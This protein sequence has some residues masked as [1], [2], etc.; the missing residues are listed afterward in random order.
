MATPPVFYP[1]G[2]IIM[3]SR[4]TSERRA[5]LKPTNDVIQAYSY[6]LG[7]LV[8]K[9]G[10][11]L[12][13]ANLVMTHD[14]KLVTDPHGDR[15]P[16]FN[17]DFNSLVARCL[18]C[19]YG[20]WE[21]F[22]AP[23]GPGDLEVAPFPEDV[24]DKLAYVLTNPV[25]DGLIERTT[26]WPALIG[27]PAFLGRQEIRVRRP[28]WFFSPDG[29]MPDWVTLRPVLPR[30]RGLNEEEVR[31]LLLERCG[32]VE[33][34]AARRREVAGRP[35]LGV[36][37]AKRRSHLAIPSTKATRRNLKPTVACKNGRLRALYL[38]YRKARDARHREALAEFRAG[39]RDV[40]F[41]VGIWLLPVLNGCERAPW[42]APVWDMDPVAPP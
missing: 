22:W 38:E 27:H 6:C 42:G 16:H 31:R 19:H 1:P 32:Q 39:R 30:V 13:G 3:S 34:D 23:G 7:Y 5:F 37:R 18:N 12:H 14:H 4:R 28:D 2:A 40:Q 24:I 35:V 17:R 15:L 11:L 8:E 20:R 33:S 29:E 10:L 26:K 25:K 41:P 9:H 36:K 21:H